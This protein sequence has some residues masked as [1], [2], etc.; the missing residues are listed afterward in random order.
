MKR[1]ALIILVSFFCTYCINE[2]APPTMNDVE[3]AKTGAE[4]QKQ[5]QT[6]MAQRATIDPQTG[7]LVNPPVPGTPAASESLESSAFSTSTEAMEEMSS[8]VPGGGVMIDLKG[9]FKIP[10]RAIVEGN[11]NTTVEHVDRDRLE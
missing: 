5:A 8:P 6:G 7:K 1:I 10:V 3:Q 9:R 11:G 2:G 4:A